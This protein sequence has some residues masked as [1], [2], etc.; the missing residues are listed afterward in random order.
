MHGLQHACALWRCFVCHLRTHVPSAIVQQ[1]METCAPPWQLHIA[2]SCA[3]P[4]TL[5]Y[6]LPLLMLGHLQAAR[7]I[8]ELKDVT[9]AE[10]TPAI[11]ALQLYLSSTKSVLRFAA[12]R[13]LNA[14]SMTQPVAGAHSTFARLPAFGAACQLMHST[15][16]AVAAYLT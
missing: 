1:R 9:M 6:C 4:R 3:Q 15:P 12:V 7:T 8:A 16:C 2:Q 11:S 13:I 5:K 14:V 10:L